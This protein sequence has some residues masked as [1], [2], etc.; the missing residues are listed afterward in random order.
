MKII[1][2]R[3][4]RNHIIIVIVILFIATACQK[5]TEQKNFE[6]EVLA[7]NLDTPWAIDFLPDDRIIFTE[8]NGKVSVLE[9]GK[10]KIVGNIKVSE[11]SESGLLGIAADPEF[12]KNR[13][14][15]VYVINCI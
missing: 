14:V 1:K 13:F 2:N 11:V 3:I 15:Y 10:I 7:E 4:M 6:F 5:Q 9:E 12:D 8:R